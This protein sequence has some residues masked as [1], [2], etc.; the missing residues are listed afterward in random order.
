MGSG[1]LLSELL[2]TLS[3]DDLSGVATM[4]QKLPQFS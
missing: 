3:N 4:I 1:Y 2:N